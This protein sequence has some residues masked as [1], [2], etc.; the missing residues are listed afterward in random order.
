MPKEETERTGR[1]GDKRETAEREVVTAQGGES[2]GVIAI[3][4]VNTAERPHKYK[5]ET[6]K[7]QPHNFC[8][9]KALHSPSTG[10]I[11]RRKA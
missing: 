10:A 3:R 8:S 11:G 4:G 9:R 2:Q 6:N 1:D 7:L 5:G